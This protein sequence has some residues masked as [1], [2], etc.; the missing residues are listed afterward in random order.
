MKSSS[1]FLSTFMLIFNSFCC[2]LSFLFVFTFSVFF[3]Y[4]DWFIPIFSNLNGKFAILYVY[5]YF[6]IPLQNLII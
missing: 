2:N 6:S 5:T 3:Y 1:V 4:V